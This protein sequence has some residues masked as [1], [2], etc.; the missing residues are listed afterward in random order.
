MTGHLFLHIGPPK[1]A[2]TALQHAFEELADETVVYGGT[3]QPRR[4]RNTGSLSDILFKAASQ[5][6]TQHDNKLES[7]LDQ[8]RSDVLS[9]KIV[10]ISEEMFGLSRSRSMAHKLAFLGEC[11][12]GLPS[13]ILLCARN[14]L[15]AIPSLYQELYRSQPFLMKLS[16]ARFCRSDAIDCYDYRKIVTLLHEAGFDT[17]RIIGF[18]QVC[19][20]KLTMQD[21]FDRPDLPDRRLGLR[22]VNT[23]RIKENTT[24]RTLEPISLKTIGRTRLVRKLRKLPPFRNDRVAGSLAAIAERIRIPNSEY[25][26]LSIPEAQ[27]S[28]YMDSY[29]FACA[30]EVPYADQAVRTDAQD[31]V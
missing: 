28:H 10:V 12:E 16:F 5:G 18:E 25:R 13:T 3:F 27:V 22:K 11:F 20:G 29:R 9:G 15:D 1:T 21:L 2:T 19:S 31:T 24:I 26:T 4:E 23:S 8:I 30:L 6:R 7:A 17:I 14:P